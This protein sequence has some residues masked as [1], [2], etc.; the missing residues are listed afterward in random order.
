MNANFYQTRVNARRGQYGGGYQV[1]FDG[2]CGGM[3]IIFAKECFLMFIIE[4]FILVVVILGGF[5]RRPGIQ[6]N[7]RPS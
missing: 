4:I 1:H 7:I 2:N 5:G 6:V 3:V